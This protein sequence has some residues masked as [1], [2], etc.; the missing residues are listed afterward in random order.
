MTRRYTA[1][2][3]RVHL[4]EIRSNATDQSITLKRNP[5]PETLNPKPCPKGGAH[6]VDARREQ[7]D[8]E[9]EEDEEEQDVGAPPVLVHDGF[10]GLLLWLAVGVVEIE[11]RARAEAR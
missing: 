3:D 5:K 7:A 9:R 11:T 2:N 4:F 10:H 6:A 1:Y 8:H